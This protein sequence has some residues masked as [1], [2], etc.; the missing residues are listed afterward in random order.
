MIKEGDK[1]ADKHIWEIESASTMSDEDRLLIVIGTSE[2]L[3]NKSDFKKAL[4]GLSSVDANKLSKII[5]DGDGSR[6][7]A[8]NG[9]YI[10]LNDLYEDKHNHSNKTIL[11]KFTIDV[12]TGKLL[13]DGVIIGSDY[14]LPIA[15]SDTLGG[16]KIDGDTI[17][18]N[19]GIISADVIGNWSA[20]INYPVGYF[21]V[22][23]EG[24]WECMV[25]HTSTSVFDESKWMPVAFR[26]IKV[27]N[28]GANTDYYLYQFVIYNNML[29]RAKEKH[30]SSSAFDESKWDLISGSTT[31]TGIN[32]W[33]TNTG[34][35][36]GNL[37]IN[38]TTIYQCNTNHTSGDTFDSTYWTSM[39]G[40]KGADGEDGAAGA[41]GSDGVT[42][43]TII[44]DI[45]NG[46]RITF[47]YTYEGG[48][49]YSIS[50][51]IENGVTPHIDE[52]T[53]HWMVGETDT[54]IVAEGKDG[55]SPTATIT[56]TD[57]GATITV[58]SGEQTT[59][60]ELTNGITPE[61]D[62]TTKHW[63]VNGEDTGVVAEGSVEINAD[64]AVLYATFVADGWSDTAPYTQIVTVNSIT[65]DN[66]PIV[67][68]SYS[69]DTSLWDGER[70]AYNC[71]TKMETLDGGVVAYCLDNKP[72][73]DFTVKLRIAGDMSGLTFVEQDEFEEFKSNIKTNSVFSEEEQIV[74]TWIDGRPLYKKTIVFEAPNQSSTQMS[75]TEYEH[76]IENVDLIWFSGESFWV[77][78]GY[79]KVM[80]FQIGMQDN[81][82]P[83]YEHTFNCSITSSTIKIMTAPA[84]GDVTVYATLLYLKTE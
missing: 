1:M 30:T 18:I 66:T 84:C 3:I 79:C 42:P 2:F 70:K 14:E 57:T 63:I 4:G 16:V 6:V 64:C 5:I 15:T 81:L 48:L 78:N 52:T 10:S 71:L 56:K 68:I 9:E 19:D 75:I 44:T 58:V 12:D 61:I 53:K 25:K 36:V 20:G 76:N 17:K 13:Y 26:A 80:A 41:K 39:T 47:K 77:T 34:Y 35:T 69:A 23:G 50:A 45:N 62:E 33:T 51:D 72:E 59:V 37:V 7:L 40:E 67:D 60:A 74:G 24:I 49:N 65:A 73:S 46:K 43:E 55:T 38:G 54:N 31:G 22:Y 32:N 83:V 29:Y 27:Y 82:T 28:W 21:V 11:D 8:N